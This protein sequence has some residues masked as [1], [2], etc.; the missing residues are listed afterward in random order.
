VDGGE[1]DELWMTE[2]FLHRPGPFQSKRRLFGRRFAIGPARRRLS[3]RTNGVYRCSN[4]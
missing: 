3:P 2:T 1:G 4:R